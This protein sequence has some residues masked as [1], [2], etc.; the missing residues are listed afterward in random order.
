MATT[1]LLEIAREARTASWALGRT[2]APWKQL[3]PIAE[4]T[5]L[6]AVYDRL[7]LG[8][9]ADRVAVR[10]ATFF[11]NAV[12]IV[13][14]YLTGLSSA[15]SRPQACSANTSVSQQCG[16]SWRAGEGAGLANP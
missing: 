3:R 16:Q 12:A 13:G 4:A 2:A 15:L 5:I 11:A 7:A 8:A 14:D 10:D 9:T 6:G 1:G